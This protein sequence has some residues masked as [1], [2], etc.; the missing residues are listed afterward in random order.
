MAAASKATS[1]SAG[2]RRPEKI[3]VVEDNPIVLLGVTHLLTMQGYD[4]AQAT[5]GAECQR[6]LGEFAPDLLLLDVVLPDASGVDI[7]RRIKCDP[8]RRHIFVVLLSAREVIPERQIS[9]LEAGADAYITRPI[10]NRELLARL[11]S[12]LRLHQA[13]TALREANATLEQRVRERTAELSA[14]NEALRE[15]V[16]VRRRAEQAERRLAERLRNLHL[17]DR[18]ILA[19]E[20]PV[21]IAGAALERIQH[22]VP[23]EAAGVV[24]MDATRNRAAVLAVFNAGQMSVGSGW[25]L[26]P[27][28]VRLLETLQT[29]RPLLIRDAPNLFLADN[30]EG[31]GSRKKW[32]AIADLPMMAEDRL[33]GALNLATNRSEG[34]SPEQ[35]EIAQEVADQ[36]AVAIRDAR[37]VEALREGRETL[38]TLSR[39]LIE[40]QE[41]ERQVIARELH[42]QI[43]QML[44]G[45]KLNLA[46]LVQGADAELRGGLDGA[47]RDMDDLLTRVRRLSLD[48]RPPL[49]DDLG[50]LTA[51]AWH[52]K[53]YTQQT[54]VRVVFKH[55]P[56][57]ARLPLIIETAVFRLVQEA[58]TNVARHAGV[59]EAVVRLLLNESHL[60][61]QVEDAGAGFVA[62]TVLQANPCSGLSGMRER[63]T[64]L[65]GDFLIESTPGSGTKVTIEFPL[66]EP[67]RPN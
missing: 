23:C 53:Q 8:E 33:V 3:L 63:A 17:I 13:E 35:I 5:T 32:R 62:E 18:A 24:E 1:P 61:I 64:L 14:A 22:L 66:N 16:T 37:L 48:L 42:D 56:W 6:L 51:L 19:A 20:S 34:F 54:G 59:S 58:L 41:Q 38:R 67:A 65:D 40:V 27:E 30:S 11:K 29:R 12:L 4:V 31:L 10:E 55:S 25:K 39:K 49:L 2:A 26:S 50:L 21:S 7:C 44:T 57:P 36:L 15:E 52:F 47:M 46:R 43:G 9:G 45:L 60:R 28:Q